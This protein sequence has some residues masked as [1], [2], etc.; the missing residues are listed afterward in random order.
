MELQVQGAG[1][2][3]MGPLFQPLPAGALELLCEPAAGI[4]KGQCLEPL[5]VLFQGVAVGLKCKVLSYYVAD[6]LQNSPFEVQ[7]LQPVCNGQLLDHDRNFPQ[8]EL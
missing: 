7:V 6:L 4:L 2:R 8:Q 5:P 3:G 1:F